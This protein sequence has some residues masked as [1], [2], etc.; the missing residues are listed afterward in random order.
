MK[1]IK[2]IKKGNK[3]YEENEEG[4]RT[5]YGTIIKTEPDDSGY[6]ITPATMLRRTFIPKNW[7]DKEE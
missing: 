7:I 1:V 3:I 2:F 6:T 4:S 5:L